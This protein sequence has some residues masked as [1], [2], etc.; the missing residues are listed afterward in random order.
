MSFPAFSHCVWRIKVPTDRYIS[1]RFLVF[2]GIN[3]A[4]SECTL[5]SIEVRDG[6]SRKDPLIGNISET[7]FVLSSHIGQL[8]NSR[9]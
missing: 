5:D 7:K 3:G 4:N 6:Y 2:T 8:C 1:L 9:R